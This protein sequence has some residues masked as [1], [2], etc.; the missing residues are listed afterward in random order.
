MSASA[1]V[2]SVSVVL[3]T[4]GRPEN[5]DE[6]TSAVLADV[7]VRHLVVVVDGED[8][9]SVRELERL[10]ARHERLVFA[11][12][13][14]AGQL[15]ALETGLTMTDAEIVLLL[16]DD[17]F[18]SAGLPSAHARAHAGR[19]RLVM[20]GSMPV[21]LSG[22]RA[23][24]GSRLYARDYEGLARALGAGERGVL[25][26]LWLGNVSIRRADALA[27]GLY[28]ASFTASYHADQDLGLRLAEAGLVGRFDETLVAEHRHRRDDRSFLRD[29]RRR[30]AGLRLLH[31]LHPSLGG[32]DPSCFTNDLPAPLGPLVRA[33]GATRLAPL[34]ARALL[35]ASRVVGGLGSDGGRVA[36]A[37][38]ARRFML[39][40]GS[41]AGEGAFYDAGAPGSGAESGGPGHEGV[42]AQRT[43]ANEVRAAS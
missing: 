3:A 36:L 15:R 8:Q 14:R 28:S 13:P 26:H 17:V 2:P 23:D 19:D 1:R 22:R 31:A 42:E 20:V 39:V 35:G 32:F 10:G 38:V 21:R 43:E 5:L 16:D 34:A 40:W 33:L 7:A 41:V 11:Q 30:G 27:H 6:L 18:P 12:V 29:A 25:E 24:V 9:A 4:M 37:K